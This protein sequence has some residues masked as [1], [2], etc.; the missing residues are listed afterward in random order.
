MKIEGVVVLYHPEDD[1]LKNIETYIN[2]VDKLYLIDNTPNVDSNDKYKKYKK[3]EYVPLKDN[4]G[5]AYALNYAAKLAIK[6]NASWLLT[7]DQDSSF[8]KDGLRKMID[9][10][11]EMKKSK[12]LNE[13]LGVNYDKIGVLSPYHI[14]N[15]NQGNLGIIKGVDYPDE[16]MTSGNLIN[17]EAYKKIK[18]FKEWLFIDCV[19]FDYCFN[20]KKHGY[21]VMVL[22][23]VYLNHNLGDIIKIKILGKEIYTD[24]HNATRWY[25]MSR[26]RKYIISL[27]SDIFPAFC[28]YQEKCTRREMLKIILFEKNKF[29][30]ISAI[31]KGSKDFKHNVKGKLIKK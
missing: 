21:E 8:Y 31:I 7:M 10:L 29:S 26:N 25:Y 17:L 22:N 11:K 3:I 20:L 4:K 1:I 14:T 15:K 12:S 16:V 24:N 18:G 6:D 28:K 30:K 23:Y 27:Y 13:I 9:F 2:Y 19:D 5:I